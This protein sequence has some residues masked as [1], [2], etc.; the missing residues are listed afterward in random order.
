MGLSWSTSSA[1]K[2]SP[3]D[4]G[5]TP[6]YSRKA[7]LTSN[8]VNVA[9]SA[10][11]LPDESVRAL[12][13]LSFGYR[14]EDLT[15]LNALPG[16]FDQRLDTWV[17]QQLDGY[18]PSYPPVNDPP[19]S[20]VVNQAGF[21]FDILDD[22]LTQLWQERVVAA[23]D[24]PEYLYPL[25][26]T[27]IF[28]LLRAV[29]SKW[30][31]A[32]V[33][34]DFWHTHFSIDGD[35]FEVAPVFVH[36]D[37]DV[38][39]P[40]MLGNFRQMLEA[41]T[42]STGMMYYLDNV[43]NTKYGPNENF[44]REIQELHTLGA[45][46]SFGF[47]PE[48]EIPEASP[49]AGSSTSLPTGLKAGYSEKDVRQ[50]T[51]CLTGWTISNQY[52][53]ELNTGEFIYYGEWH[54]T[55]TKKVL[56]IDI[57]SSGQSEVTQVLDLLA[58]HPNTARYVCR[59][60]CSRLIGDNPPESIIEA[61]A[62]VFNDQWQAADQLKQVVKTIILS[63]EFKDAAN[64][65]TKTKRPFELLA[66]TARSCGGFTTALK[67]P[68]MTSWRNN[69]QLGVGY[70][71]TL[72][73][74]YQWRDTGHMLFSWTTPD[75][76]PDTKQAWLGATPLVMSWRMTNMMFMNYFPD[77]PFNEGSDWHTYMPI[78]AVATTKNV[79]AVDQ[80]SAKNIV[81]YWVNQF[82]GYDSNLP[83]SPQMD[84]QTILK[85]TNFMQQDA[86][87]EDTVL[88]LDHNEWGNANWNTYVEQRLQ[89]LV[90]SISMLPDNLLR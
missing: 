15:A 8:S 63:S 23:P 31:L 9:S 49:M 3:A 53:D 5:F 27:R 54:D 1:A 74:Y 6:L 59:K 85:L 34:A 71:F 18:Q 2:T 67:R 4:L 19:L 48:N 25:V 29:N 36:Y 20:A 46:H 7:K 77:D 22:S 58:I 43:W 78:D 55:S 37:R 24:W 79:L 61:A 47:T 50:L 11:T 64:W 13:K 65:G 68:D 70:A 90:A 84:A 62:V 35:K 10:S 82:F 26:E 12:R 69:L 38:I 88:D 32:E 56:G 44:A 87:S 83:G 17:N 28:S 80:R 42:K 72:D 52:T 75:G 30:Q 51:F 41:V 33:L 21:N 76:F 73:L 40:N 89:T 39:R 16:N 45:I 14:P 60:L 81:A 86:S 57:N 66:G